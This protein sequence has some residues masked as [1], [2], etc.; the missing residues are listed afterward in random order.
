MNEISTQNMT[1][2]PELCKRLDKAFYAENPLVV[3]KWRMI[4]SELI[5]LLTSIND[6][7]A[8]HE[9][10]SC[11]YRLCCVIDALSVTSDQQK[12]L[13]DRGRANMQTAHNQL[14]N[15]K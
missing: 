4:H 9:A 13:N 11:L 2:N 6:D 15:Y 8:K 14:Q 10:T 1:V 7:V 3:K 5:T 12:Y